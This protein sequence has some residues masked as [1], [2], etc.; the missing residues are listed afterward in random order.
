[1]LKPLTS[2]RCP[3]CAQNLDL[4]F[5]DSAEATLGMPPDRQWHC[6]GCGYSRPVVYSV[7]RPVVTS[8]L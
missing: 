6:S 2:A 8:H 7:V 3:N 4:G 1:M 5:A